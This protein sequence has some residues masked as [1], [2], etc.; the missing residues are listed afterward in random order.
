M[1]TSKFTL[2]Q[3]VHILRQAESGVQVFC[4]AGRASWRARR[5]S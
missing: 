3:V 5:S 4:S 2:E 1:R